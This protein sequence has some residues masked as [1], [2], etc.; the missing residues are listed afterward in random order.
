MATIATG[1]FGQ[2]RLVER[3]HLDQLDQLDLLHE[4]LGDAVAAMHHDGLG[5]IQIDQCDLDLAAIA[6]VD[7]ARTVDDRKP[8][9]RSQS[10]TRVNQ[11]D[12]SE[13]NRDGHARAH[14]GASSRLQLEVFRA[15]EIDAGVALMGAR[16]QWQLGIEANDGQTG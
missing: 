8:H 13:G 1:G 7:C 5:R 15:V 4:Q 11:A 16:G 14:Q 9:A 6:G 3:R 2:A 12:H 10:R